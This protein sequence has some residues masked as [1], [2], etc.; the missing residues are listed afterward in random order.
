MATSY[1]NAPRHFVVGSTGIGTT[2]GTVSPGWDA[3]HRASDIGLLPVVTPIGVTASLA[4]PAGFT[5]VA[6]STNTGSDTAGARLAL[7]WARAD[8][9]TMASNGGIMPSP[10]ISFTG[11]NIYSLIAGYRGC[12]TQGS[13]IH[14]FATGNNGSVAGTSL[15]VSGLTT[16]IDDCLIV[17]F[18]ATG[19]DSAS[20]SLFTGIASTNGDVHYLAEWLE[21]GSSSG[22]GGGIM[23]ADGIKSTAGAVSAITATRTSGLHAWIAVA[24]EPLQTIAP[25]VTVVSPSSGATGPATAWVVDVT[26][27][28][29]G[30]SVTQASSSQPEIIHDGANFLGLYSSCSRSAVTDGYRYTLARRSGWTGIPTFSAITGRRS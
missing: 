18:V 17:V 28:H 6:S 29:A 5:L 13:P 25:T 15:S 3:L 14:A 22:H 27:D 16:T 9:A 8:A 10:G 11:D 30:L 1:G 24:L 23:I 2:S 26:G 7:Y 12:R 19:V 20:P 21:E 4:T